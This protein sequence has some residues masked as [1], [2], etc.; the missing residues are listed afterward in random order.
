MK[1]LIVDDNPQVREIVGEYCR[2]SDVIMECSDG[3][4]AVSAY[5]SFHPDW[6]VMDIVMEPMNG[7]DAMESILRIN[8]NAR[9]IMMTQFSD[10]LFQQKAMQKGAV[11][12]LRKEE[13]Q[14]L[15]ELISSSSF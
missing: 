10:P 7:F 15:P 12:L 14:H 6:V 1:I 4:E 9:I 5:E 3:T 8:R 11:A 2:N 13:L